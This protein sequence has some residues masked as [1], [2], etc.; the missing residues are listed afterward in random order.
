M[1]CRGAGKRHGNGTSETCRTILGC[2]CVAARRSIASFR[3][4]RIVRHWPY[5]AFLKHPDISRS[6]G[7]SPLHHS[8]ASPLG[9][10]WHVPCS[11]VDGYGERRMGQG[12]GRDAPGQRDARILHLHDNGC[13]RS[14]TAVALHRIVVRDTDY[15]A[16]ACRSAV[17]AA[18]WQGQAIRPSAG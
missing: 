14:D 9:P 7:V 1:N 15:R 4:R 13:L 11:F 18:T 8:G 3:R 6:V 17:V 5:P 12:H 2:R 16:S 10:V